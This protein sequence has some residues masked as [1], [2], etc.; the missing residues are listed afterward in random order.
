MAVESVTYLGD[1]NPAFPAP[2][3]PKSEGDD[4][5]RNI[6]RALKSTLPN[7]KGA[8][9]LTEEEINALP[10]AVAAKGAVTGQTWAGTH[11][12]PATTYGV[13]AP[14][15]A[16][17]SK[18]ATLD[19]VNATA[20]AGTLPGQ[21]GNRGKFVATNGTTANFYSVI[22]TISVFEVSTPWVADASRIR[23]TV[24]GGGGGS[25][26]ALSGTATGGHGAG[27]AIKTLDV[28]IG[29]TYMITIGAGGAKLINQSGNPPGND[30]SDSSFSGPGITPITGG[31]GGGGG[32]KLNGSAGVGSGGDINLAGGNTSTSL[33]TSNMRG[34]Y[35]HWGAGVQTSKDGVNWGEGGGS[36]TSGGNGTAGKGGVAV[37]ERVII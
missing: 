6:K 35:S 24:T 30:G 32:N 21:S 3:D 9:T 13:T 34:G 7:I 8:M 2:A 33:P 26:T 19:F 20:L 31:G 28:V 16:S 11:Q 5:I 36:V 15:G 14:F 29:A 10:A 1:L 27:T 25:G 22:P 23:L 4:H 17:G 12:F 18:L 37:I